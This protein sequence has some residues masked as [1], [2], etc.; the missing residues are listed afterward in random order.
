MRKKYVY[1]IYVYI[2]MYI[3]DDLRI[4]EE[5]RPAAGVHCSV[6]TG[7]DTLLQAPTGTELPNPDHLARRANRLRETMRPRNPED[8]LFQLNDAFVPVG[9]LQADVT[10]D[11]RRHLLFATERMLDLLAR[12]KHW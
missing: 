11:D 2:Y 7:E 4:G 6:C 12:A 1:V 10:V 8:L 3:N 9:F 5:R